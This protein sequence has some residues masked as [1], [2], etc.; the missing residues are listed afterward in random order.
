M[1][2]NSIVSNAVHSYMEIM[3]SMRG[4]VTYLSKL[5]ATSVN[6]DAVTVALP[7]KLFTEQ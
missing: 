7:M 4:M 2:I 3:K 1:H 5:I 6:T